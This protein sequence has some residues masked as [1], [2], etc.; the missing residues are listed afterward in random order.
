MEQLLSAP[1]RLNSFSF[2]ID[3]SQSFRIPRIYRRFLTFPSR[4]PA[5]RRLSYLFSIALFDREHRAADDGFSD[6]IPFD[7]LD[8]RTCLRLSRFELRQNHRTMPRHPFVWA[9]GIESFSSAKIYDLKKSPLNSLK[10]IFQFAITTRSHAMHSRRTRARMEQTKSSAIRSKRVGYPLAARQ[11]R[12]ASA[13]PA[14]RLATVSHSAR[15]SRCRSAL[16]TNTRTQWYRR[17]WISARHWNRFGRRYFRESQRDVCGVA[18]GTQPS[19]LEMSVATVA[20]S[21]RRLSL[22]CRCRRRA[23][24]VAAVLLL[25]V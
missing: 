23:P 2:R 3:S 12:R 25:L 1:L 13:A 22:C 4:V 8:E 5:E 24:A 11:R 21:R 9:N 6:R 15:R 20:H 17:L 19:R 14:L 18:R 7:P 10:C 16:P